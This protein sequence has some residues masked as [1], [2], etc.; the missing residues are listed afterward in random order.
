MGTNTG[1]SG[2]NL[3][4]SSSSVMPNMKAPSLERKNARRKNIKRSKE[5]VVILNERSDENPEGGLK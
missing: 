2:E 4:K 3:P 5:N 1:M